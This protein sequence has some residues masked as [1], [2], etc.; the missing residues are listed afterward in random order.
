[1]HTFA[2]V[3]LE[4][5]RFI[6][7][8]HAPH[9]RPND[10]VRSVRANDEVDV[11]SLAALDMYSHTLVVRKL[12]DATDSLSGEH[13]ALPIFA[14]VAEQD[15]QELCAGPGPDSI[16]P[17]GLVKLVE[18]IVL[19]L[20]IAIDVMAGDASDL[21]RLAMYLVEHTKLV[22]NSLEVGVQS[23]TGSDFGREVV[24]G[25]QEYKVDFKAVQVQSGCKAS[26]A[27]ANDGNFEGSHD[28][29]SLGNRTDIWYL[30]GSSSEPQMLKGQRT[31]YIH[32]YLRLLY[33]GS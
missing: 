11:M 33:E 20:Q 22:D 24:V 16:S 15:L 9:L 8:S 21:A 1:L 4:D 14:R 29:L 2:L 25:L 12:L 27:A 3:V 31:G 5:L 23:K 28:D 7:F 10:T 19:V 30:R 6:F 32:D 18:D 26:H 17:S 13:L